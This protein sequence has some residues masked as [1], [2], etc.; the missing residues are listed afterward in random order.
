MSTQIPPQS[1]RQKRE[2]QQPREVDIIP[3]DLPNVLIKF[4]ASDTGE[5]V[6]GSIRVPGDITEKQLEELLN[7][8]NG[9]S[10]EPVPYTFSLQTEKDLVDIKNNLYSSV[11]KPGL[12]TT[13]D[14][15]TLVYTVK[16]TLQTGDSNCWPDFEVV[17]KVVSCGGIFYVAGSL[18]PLG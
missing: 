14:F 18:E 7:E 9:T 13:E 3:S 1:K 5:S 17:T 16:D 4:E 12:K 11:L 10:D 8:L 15:M 2:A 6:G